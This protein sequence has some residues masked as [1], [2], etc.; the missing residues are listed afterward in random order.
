MPALGT[1]V[2]P[3]ADL[4]DEKPRGRFRLV[5]ISYAGYWQAADRGESAKEDRYCRECD[6][7]TH[8]QSLVSFDRATLG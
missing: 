1:Q 4:Q 8:L 2:G 7:G 5:E 6:Y 3:R